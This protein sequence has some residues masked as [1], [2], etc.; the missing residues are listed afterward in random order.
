MAD[1]G[2]R[3]AGA[4]ST[5]VGGIGF[6]AAALV[7]SGLLV[8]VYLALVA[9]ALPPTQYLYFSS[10]WSLTLLV[11]FG[12]FLPIEQELIRSMH[13]RPDA[14]APIR[15]ALRVALGLAAVDVALLLAASPLLAHSLGHEAG[16]Y[17]AL[18]VFCLVSAGQFVVRGVLIGQGRMRAYAGV[19]LLDVLLRVVLA[20]VLGVISGASG[21]VYAGAL[22]VAVALAHLPMLIALLRRLPDCTGQRSDSGVPS[23]TAR[24]LGR[25]VGP[26]LLGSLAAQLLLNGIPV[27][28]A[29]TAAH[30]DQLAAGRFQAAFQLVRIP[31]FLAVPLQTTILPALTALFRHGSRATVRAVLVRF[32]GGV[33]VLALA[34]LAIGYLAGPLLLRLVFGPGYDYSRAGLALLAVGVAAYLGLIVLTQALVA[35]ALHVRVGMSWLAALVVAVFAYLAVPDVLAAAEWSFVL[36]SSAGLITGLILLPV[37]HRDRMTDGED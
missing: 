29:A 6:V 10:Y 32:V 33:A 23:A 14:P 28:I 9:R 15:P 25:A 34:G 21:P 26:L 37:W 5:G 4:A 8:N 27:V 2:R 11:G 22:V 1:P 3:A 12:V 13:D 36:G 31:L 35:T 7:V 18:I 19:L 24:S 20:A 16:F 30:S 17:V